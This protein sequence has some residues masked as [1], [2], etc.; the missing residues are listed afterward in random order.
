MNNIETVHLHFGM[1]LVFDESRKDGNGEIWIDVYNIVRLLDSHRSSQRKTQ[2]GWE[3]VYPYK[4]L[5]VPEFVPKKIP[6]GSP[7]TAAG[8]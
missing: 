3:R 1:E 6:E 2:E 4:D 8:I 5:D 7:V